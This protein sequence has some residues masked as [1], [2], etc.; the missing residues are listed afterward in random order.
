MYT[1][2]LQ[3]GEFCW[4]QLLQAQAEQKAA[5][6]ASKP[7]LLAD[8]RWGFLEIMLRPG[9][10]ALLFRKDGPLNNGYSH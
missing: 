7:R 2:W 6:K 8:A 1:N 4:L 9:L 5:E 3:L 10:A